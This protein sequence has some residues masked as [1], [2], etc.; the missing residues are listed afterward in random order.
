MLCYMTVW[1]FV[2]VSVMMLEMFCVLCVEP[3]DDFK[4]TFQGELCVES[5][6]GG[7]ACGCDT[8][9]MGGGAKLCASNGQT[10]YNTYAMDVDACHHKVPLHVVHYGE[11]GKKPSVGVV[12]GEFSPFQ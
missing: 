1:Y 7:P 6:D 11:C 2:V 9:I 5:I 8:G 10:Y 4:C 3:C 12:W